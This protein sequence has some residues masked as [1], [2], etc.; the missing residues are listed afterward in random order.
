MVCGDS[1]TGVADAPQPGETTT[2]SRFDHVHL[3]VDVHYPVCT[4]ALPSCH[5]HLCGLNALRLPPVFSVPS[6]LLGDAVLCRERQ[7]LRLRHMVKRIARLE[8]WVDP[9]DA[10]LAAEEL[11]R[12]E[13]AAAAAAEALLNVS[14]ILEV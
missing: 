8:P 2:V 11:A 4:E 9:K 14:A 3:H 7:V 10:V 1:L 6:V 5:P 12:R 13:A